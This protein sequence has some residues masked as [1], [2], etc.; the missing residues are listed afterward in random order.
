[1]KK[2]F[3]GC[4][5]AT[6]LILLTGT[7]FIW[8]VLFR[9]LPMLDATLALPTE[10][11]VE[12][13]VDMVVTV[14]NP[15]SEAVTLDSID[16]DAA[17]LEGFQVVGVEPEPK[18]TMLVPFLNQRSWEFG[19]VLQSG[20]THSVT[21]RLKSVMEGR[22]SGDIDICNPNQDYKTL[23]ADIVVKEEWNNSLEDIGADRAES[24]H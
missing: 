20:E 10:A 4:L 24:S 8:F 15:H 9:E 2:I 17:F 18:G 21:F 1:M 13:P 23:L 14:S 22:F 19:K 3:L 7:A 6:L 16:V 12:S 5:G 11:A